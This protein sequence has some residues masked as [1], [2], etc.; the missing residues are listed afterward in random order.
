MDTTLA[1][2]NRPIQQEDIRKIYTKID[3]KWK[4]VAR[5]LGPTSLAD[6]EI[7]G[8]AEGQSEEQCYKMLRKWETK[9]RHNGKVA[10]V[11]HLCSAL[12]HFNLSD[13]AV[14]VFGEA[15]VHEVSQLI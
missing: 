4:Q 11:Y 3:H 5:L 7:D 8:I 1:V 6:Y 10:S 13:A 15:T 12:I 9:Q 14:D 2:A